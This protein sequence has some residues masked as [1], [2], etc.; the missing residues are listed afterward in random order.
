MI[1]TNKNINMENTDNKN[2]EMTMKKIKE[3]VSLICGN[4]SRECYYILCC[5]INVALS[6]QPAE[7]QMK[8]LCVEVAARTNK[9]VISVE[10][11]VGRA[12]DDI[13]RHGNR[14]MLNKFFNHILLQKPKPKNLI[15]TLS[16]Y[17][18]INT[19]MFSVEDSI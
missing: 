1:N 11:S 13:W 5:A 19:G 18:W 14:E 17:L 9:T 4:R 6:Y 15:F 3:L 10:K 8:L 16:E 2:Y 12:V 7:P